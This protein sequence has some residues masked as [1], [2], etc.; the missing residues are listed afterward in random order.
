V[1]IV[2]T[3]AELDLDRS[4]PIALV[5]TMGAFH[6]GH[7]SLM[8]RA[9]DVAETVVVSLF[10]NPTQFMAGEDFEKY[11]RDEDRDFT[12]AREVGVDVMFAPA[13]ADMYT[14]SGTVV[15]VRGV[16]ERWEGEHRPGHFDGVATVVAKLF[17]IVRP[18]VALFGLKDFQQC[19]VIDRMVKDL[20]IPL[21][22]MFEETIREPDGLA[23]SS[24]NAYLSP[25]ERRV[26]PLLHQELVRL[27]RCSQ[28]LKAEIGTSHERLTSVGFRVD[29]LA[30]VD[31][32]TLEPVEKTAP[33]TR[34]IAAARL[35]GTRLIDNIAVQ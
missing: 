29:Y 6:E 10:V 11:P 21:V 9:R 18:D 4:K 35:G 34:L 22:L 7:L 31:S 30:L 33:E 25:E 16:T 13:V 14:G 8:R 23:M 28:P 2:R 17:N 15:H 32:A 24:R 27:S 12:L 20:N 19:V 5:P 1:K 26:A 3:I